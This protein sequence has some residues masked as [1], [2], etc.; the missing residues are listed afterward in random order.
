MMT[1]WVAKAEA[2]LRTGQPNLA[3]LYMRRGL[4]ECPF[5][6]WAACKCPTECKP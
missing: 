3:K 5:W 2:A 4:T 1:G 6:A